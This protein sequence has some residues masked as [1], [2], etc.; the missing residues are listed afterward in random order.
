MKKLKKYRIKIS[1][2]TGNS[3]GSEDT[4]DY[5]EITWDDIDI[6]KENLQRIR[7][8]YEMYKELDG[9][10]IN[11]SRQS[12]FEKNKKTVKPVIL[13]KSKTIKESK[14]FQDEF[15]RSMA[16]LTTKKLGEIEANAKDEFLVKMFKFHFVTFVLL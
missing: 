10:R 5:L 9:Y 16:T 6:A 13:F 12:I 11:G 2:Q 15:I 4:T 7:E 1:Y 8:H 14:E 3:F